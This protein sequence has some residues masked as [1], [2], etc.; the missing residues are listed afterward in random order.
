[1]SWE[2]VTAI[3][4]IIGAI[5]VIVTLIYLARQV[6]MSNKFAK[7]DAWRSRFSEFTSLNA[8]YGVNPIFYHAM[9]KVYNGGL[10]PELDK[11][12]ESL[13]NSFLI[14]ALQIYE[15]LFREVESDILD[16]AALDE[17]PGHSG[18]N[19]PFFKAQWPFYRMILTSAVAEH[20]EEKYDLV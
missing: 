3:S 14:S 7:A 17:F 16:P 9:N 15:Q 8:A 5:A 12:E 10:P 19:L 13:V 6:A 4:E 18:F 1:M 20:L 11:D 2:S